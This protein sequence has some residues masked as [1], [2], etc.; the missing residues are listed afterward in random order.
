MLMQNIAPAME[1]VQTV[2]RQSD[3]S[4]QDDRKR[5]RSISRTEIRDPEKEP[6]FVW[7]Q[8]M[9]ILGGWKISLT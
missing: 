6:L 9:S 1:V 7:E 2:W 8:A 4:V 5:K 3:L